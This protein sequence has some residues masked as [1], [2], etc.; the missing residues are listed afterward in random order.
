MH[1]FTDKAGRRW[2]IE[3]TLQGVERVR[4]TV[5]GV[6][7]LDVVGGSAA[8]GAD[9]LK[10]V[11]V[12]YEL[13]P[14]EL[15]REVTLENLRGSMR[16]VELE[17]ATEALLAEWLDFFPPRNRAILGRLLEATKKA[18]S[19]LLER[20]ERLTSRIESAGRSGSS[21]APPDS[22]PGSSTSASSAGPPAAGCS[23]SAP[24]P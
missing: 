3:L 9:P 19:R 11:N 20:I 12:I 16:G 22:T 1:T 14:A 5:P 8:L 6:D 21:P 7:L 13:A 24:P 10:V 15:R 23:P 18:E 17:A 4:G 2:E